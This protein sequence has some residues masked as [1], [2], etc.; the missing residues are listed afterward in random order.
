MSV[1]NEWC[2]Y[3]DHGVRVA[4]IQQ[5][6]DGFTNGR[7]ASGADVAYGQVPLEVFP[8]FDEARADR[9]RR[10]PPS[11]IEWVQEPV[12]QCPRCF[13][14]FLDRDGVRVFSHP[15]LYCHECSQELNA[16]I[17]STVLDEDIAR[18]DFNRVRR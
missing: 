15:N 5:H 7:T 2:G 12:S 16:A 3:N 4:V 17:A 1:L 13:S 10:L 8:T 11:P 14:S 6:D 18:D 9:L